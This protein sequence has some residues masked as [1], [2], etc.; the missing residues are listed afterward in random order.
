M[1]DEIEQRLTSTVVP[2]GSADGLGTRG[3]SFATFGSAD[4]NLVQRSRA[5]GLN[6]VFFGSALTGAGTDDR[7]GRGIVSS[8][9][10]RT[11]R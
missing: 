6:P 1:L 3:A 8:C 7:A 9:S 10:S 4:G 11:R 5:G 2:M